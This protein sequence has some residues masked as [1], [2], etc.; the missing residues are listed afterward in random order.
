M[1][2]I[3]TGLSFGALWFVI[4]YTGSFTLLW[5]FTLLLGVFAL[6][7]FFTICLND[8]EKQFKKYII[9][10]SS[11]PL[12]ASYSG[13]FE[14]TMA[15][16]IVSL[17]ATIIMLF[18]LITK[19]ENAFILAAKICSGTAFVSLLAAHL[20]LMMALDNGAKWV[21]MLTIITVASDTGAYYTGSNFGRN[22]LCSSISP[23]KTI[24][25]FIGG[26]VSSIFFAVIAG[27]F[28]FPEIK[29]NMIALVAMVVSAISVAGDLS[30]SILK[31]SNNIKD[32]GNILPG[33][34]GLL[35]R[36]DSILAA[37]PALYYF[38]CLGLI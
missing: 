9:P 30:E 27:Y 16:F 37:T 34:G 26:I 10:I 38:V 18:V 13:I 36:V 14:V 15:S 29:Y 33:H 4:L 2:R 17:F 12:L 20:P 5:G 32:S 6:H 25:G 21:V 3:V 28:L 24:E 35:D 22:K 23:G 7:E 31:R 11:I 1:N 19:I 8:S